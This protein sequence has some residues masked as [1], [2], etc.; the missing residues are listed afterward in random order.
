M[1]ELQ[2]LELQELIL[3]EN[4]K[5]IWYDGEDCL[6][7][8]DTKWLGRGVGKEFEGKDVDECLEKMHEYLLEHAY[9]DD[10][11][12]MKITQSGYPDLA[13]VRIYL[14]NKKEEEEFIKNMFEEKELNLVK[15]LKDVPP[16]TK[17]YLYSPL[18]GV[19]EFDG[20]RRGDRICVIDCYKYVHYF[21]EHGN[22]LKDEGECLLFPSRDN[23]DWRTFK[24]EKGFE[25]GDQQ[26]KPNRT[27]KCS[28][29]G[30]EF[31]EPI[32]HRCNKN[33]RKKH[34]KW[35]NLMEMEEKRKQFNVADFISNTETPVETRDGRKVE[36]FT[37][38]RENEDTHVVVGVMGEPKSKGE[39][40]SDYYTSWTKEGKFYS[41][42]TDCVGD[43]FFSAKK[44]KRRMTNQE[45]AWWL[46][47]HSEEH[48]EF[49]YD[50]TY[51]GDGLVRY[52]HAYNSLRA[53]EEV[54]GFI[55]IRS[56][57]GEWKEPLFDE[58]E[59]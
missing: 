27:V 17:L 20:V 59:K 35:I 55:K 25:V 52:E 14:K 58:V 54:D 39:K 1:D 12:G 44:K 50:P 13:K 22:F 6:W 19:C 53:H 18:F 23:H 28:F 42:A 57:G 31:I 9:Y 49:T 32:P 51:Q 34:L 43:L 56:N 33:Y 7:Y 48:R 16:G 26:K 24:V 5:S 40:H 4:P 36:I 2:L 10:F 8:V 41:T 15:I 29:C 21:Y 46:R 38:T 45:L 11:A 37:T 30:R 47:E 3:A